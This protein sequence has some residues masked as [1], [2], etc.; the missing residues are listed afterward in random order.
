MGVVAY[1]NIEADQRGFA[2]SVQRAEQ[3]LAQLH[4]EIGR[5]EERLSDMRA[6]AIKLGH[7]VEMARE[8]GD[9]PSARGNETASST[10]R[11]A[12]GRERAPKGGMSGRA[13]Q[14]CISILRER[15]EPM[16]TTELHA[17]IVDR[18][19]MLGGKNPAQA[20]SGYLS[21]TPEAVSDR[22]RGWSLLEW[23]EG[24]KQEVEFDLSSPP[25]SAVAA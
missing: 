12:E 21:R 2:M 19:I 14:E 15:H 16:H 17:L 20:L 6:R 8:F 7:Y 5:I 3:E 4:R 10:V 24:S 25:Q 22:S 9:R 23:Q 1:S 18:G 11:S 13:V